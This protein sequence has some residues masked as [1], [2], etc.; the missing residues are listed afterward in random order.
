[1]VFQDEITCIVF[2][3]RDYFKIK[4]FTPCINCEQFRLYFQIAKILIPN[5][6]KK[7]HHIGEYGRMEVWKFGSGVI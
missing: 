4:A 6:L 2:S 7:R 5:D 3:G 1:M